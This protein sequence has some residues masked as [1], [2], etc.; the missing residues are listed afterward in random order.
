MKI[1]KAT[2]GGLKVLHAA[3]AP[4]TAQ[5]RLDPHVDWV[6]RKVK[7]ASRAPRCFSTPSPGDRAPD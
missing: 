5:R 3:E 7:G 1:K 4:M 2:A 6:S